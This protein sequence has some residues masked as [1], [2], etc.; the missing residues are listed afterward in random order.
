MDL[1]KKS[2]HRFLEIP[3]AIKRK[4]KDEVEGGGC[5]TVQEL[6]FAIDWIWDRRVSFA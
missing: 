5:H 4:D 2:D 3:F 6:G 1:F